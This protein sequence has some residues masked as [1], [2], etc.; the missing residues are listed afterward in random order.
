MTRM[1]VNKRFDS[2][3]RYQEC[4]KI[5]KHEEYIMAAILIGAAGLLSV[6]VNLIHLIK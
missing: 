3:K 5:R 4:L 6:I 2:W 1:K